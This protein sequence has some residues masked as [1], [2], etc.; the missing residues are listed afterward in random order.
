MADP[1]TRPIPHAAEVP[2]SMRQASRNWELIALK[3]RS[4][5][6]RRRGHIVDLYKS[7]RWK[8]YYTDEELLTE[9]RAADAMARRWALIA[10]LPEEREPAAVEPSSEAALDTEQSKAA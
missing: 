6:E 9:M 2:L 3:W 5:A 4:L 1:F 7:G 8:R 10:P